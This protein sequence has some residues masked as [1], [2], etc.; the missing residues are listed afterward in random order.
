MKT[1]EEYLRLPYRI[2][3]THDRDEEGN[4]GYVAEVDELPGAYSQGATPEEAVQGIRD[5]MA[6]WLSI[7]LEDGVPIPEP[8]TTE[9][10]SGR[11]L[12]RL[13][14]TLHR[15]LTRQAKKEGVSVNQFIT[16]ALAGAVEWRQ[17][18]PPAGR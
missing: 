17:P 7:A 18:K 2:V 8:L 5:A 14:Q 9:K 11:I 6:G 16:A 15:E 10:Y 4:E 1:I 13:P 12:V 3:L